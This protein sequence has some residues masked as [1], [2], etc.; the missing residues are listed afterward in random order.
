MGH[1]LQRCGW[2][3]T[4][5]AR[6]GVQGQFGTRPWCCGLCVHLLAPGFGDSLCLALALPRAAC[7]RGCRFRS[8]IR[9]LQV[10]SPARPPS[11]PRRGGR[12]R[13]RARLP[14]SCSGARLPPRRR[15]GKDHFP[16]RTL[17]TSQWL[18][19]RGRWPFARQQEQGEARRRRSGHSSANRRV[20]PRVPRGQE[21]PRAGF[22]LWHLCNH[23]VLRLI[24]VRWVARQECGVGRAPVSRTRGRLV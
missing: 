15:D 13:H 10:A 1:S 14:A 24:L 18:Q 8:R 22:H 12:R 5:T 9:H 17:Q 19:H 11:R 16:R 23:A 21:L 3:S 6:M 4:A 7:Q 2:C 20:W